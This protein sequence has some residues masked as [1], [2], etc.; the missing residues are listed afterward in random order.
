MKLSLARIPLLLLA[1]VALGAG[2]GCGFVN[3]IRAKNALNEGAR[4]YKDGKFPEAQA[5]FEEAL[6]LDPEQ[7]YAPV[8]RARAI[9]QQYKPGVD[10]PENLARGNAAIEAFKALLEKDPNNDEAFTNVTVLY[11]N[12]RDEEKE[13]AW[14]MQRANSESA[15]KDKRSDVYTILASKQWNCSFDITEQKENKATVTKGNAVVIEYKKPANQEDFDR[16]RA[17]VDRGLELAQKAIDLNPDN[18]SAWSYKTNLLREQSKF[19]QME[20]NAEQKA[21]FDQQASEAEAIQ[22][23]LTEEQAKKK[24]AEQAKKSPTPP[25]G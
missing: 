23:R 3:K 12:M 24:E 6:A 18:P 22:A 2:S 7:Q 11:R 13:N 20:G 10:T 19:A 17:C 14:L 8:F 25:A 15:P 16:A 21:Q 5:K 9:L 1:F 4:A